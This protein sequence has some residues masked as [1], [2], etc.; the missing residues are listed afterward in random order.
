VAALFSGDFFCPKKI[1][2]KG[3][4][5]AMVNRI[6]GSSGIREALGIILCPL[7]WKNCKKA[8]LIWLLF[9][10]LMDNPF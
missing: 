9:I 6:V 8:S 2:L 5:P 10:F 3:T 4:M 7:E 1:G